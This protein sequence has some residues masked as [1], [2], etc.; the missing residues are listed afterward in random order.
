[1]TEQTPP[2]T[3]F[4]IPFQVPFV[5]RLRFTRD[6][7]GAD[8]GVLLNLLEPTGDRPARVQFWIDRHVAAAQPALRS[9][10]RR[11]VR[12]SA[13]RLEMPGNIQ[14]VPGGEEVKNDIH[15]LERMLK[16]I[17]AADLDRRSYVVA[18]GGGA[19]LDAVGF[20]AAIAHRGIRLVRLPTTTLAQGDSGVGVKNSVNLFRK[21][22]WVGTFAAPWG[23]VNDETLL[24]T[25]PLRD[26]RCG[27][28]EAVKVSLL[29]DPEAFRSLCSVADRIARR[30]MTVAGPAIQRSAELHL[31][32][33]TRGGDPFEALEARPLDFGHWSAH[34]L[35]VLSNFEL[36]H[37][38]AVAIGLALDTR[39]SVQIGMLAPGGDERVYAL[40]K[41]LGF[42]LWHPLMESRDPEGHWMLLRG[43]EEFREHLGGELTI[44]LLREI[45]Q[46]EEVHHMEADHILRAI[47]WLHRREAG[48]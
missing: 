10:I 48:Q 47:S 12:Q 29:K 23:V 18:I 44:T 13:G 9:R 3:Q 21:K 26:F 35:E 19:V 24:S 22:N 40:L 4:D 5:H 30:D 11:L 1:M 41:K 45:G 27:F 36:R 39:Y 2:P 38:E 31:A 46:G 25:L 42:Y 15:L 34:K 16:C 17:H 28:S 7:F 43:L 6:L 33:I 20:A 32:H 8:R 14:I 37:G